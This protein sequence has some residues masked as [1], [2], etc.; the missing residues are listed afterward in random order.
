MGVTLILIL[1][2]IIAVLFLV[3]NRTPDQTEVVLPTSPP[4]V[5]VQ[6]ASPSVSPS[7][8]PTLEPPTPTVTTTNSP[9][10]TTSPSPSQTAPPTAIPDTPIPAL[11]PVPAPVEIALGVTLY[12]VSGVAPTYGR[13]GGLYD[14]DE[15]IQAGHVMITVP[16]D[17]QIGTFSIDAFEVANLQLV[18]YLN[19]TQLTDIPLDGWNEAIAGWMIT[20]DDE[21][22]LRQDDLGTWQVRNARYDF[23]PARGVSALTARAYCINLGGDLPT[24]EQWQRAA[25]WVQGAEPRP[26]PWGDTAL[27]ST[28]A[29]F[30]SDS[31]LVPESLAA[32]RSWIGAYH[33]AGN[34]AEWVQID[35]QRF[36][37]IGGSFL[38]NAVDFD[39]N[40]RN[41][42]VYDASQALP[43][44][45]FRCVRNPS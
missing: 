35:A 29:N 36:G 44:A 12:D 17:A 18:N 9:E 28:F 41:V 8:S 19:A 23:L 31:P 32:G 25:F 45:G 15:L 10:P 27:D 42:Q 14:N 22:E 40:L 20:G 1:L 4:T 7:P 5:I 13:F 37:I 16:G 11:P 39:Q 34:V 3:L 2:I 24:L 30:A 6:Q 43:G 26:Y 21:V 38:D 33:M